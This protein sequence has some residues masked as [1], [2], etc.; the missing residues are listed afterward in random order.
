MPLSFANQITLEKSPGYSRRPDV[1]KRVY[2]WNPNIKMI[3]IIR[4]PVERAI[5]NYAHYLSTKLKLKYN[6]TAYDNASKLFDDSILRANGSV[7]FHGWITG[8]FYVRQYK[9]W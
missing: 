3:L 8:G 5:S 6:S 4:D 1:A 7:R 2:D 9:E